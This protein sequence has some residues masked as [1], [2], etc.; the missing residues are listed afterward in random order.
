MTYSNSIGGEHATT[1]NGNG[2]NP[3]MKDILAVAAQIKLNPKKAK[4]IATD[5]QE[6]VNEELKEY[7]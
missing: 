4:T 5:I 2:R 6:I 7:I 3:Q 1:V